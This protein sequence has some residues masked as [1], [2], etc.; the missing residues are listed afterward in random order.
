MLKLK[1]IGEVNCHECNGSI[2]LDEIMAVY[3]FIGKRCP[4]CGAWNEIRVSINDG[5]LK[6]KK[7]KE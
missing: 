1:L 6:G 5:K 3:N 7:E 4:R 2:E